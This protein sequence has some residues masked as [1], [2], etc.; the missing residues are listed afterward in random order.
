MP[1]IC[2]KCSGLTTRCQYQTG[3]QA[4]FSVSQR[5]MTEVQRKVEAFGNKFHLQLHSYHCKFYQHELFL[6]IIT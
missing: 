1:A 4:H 2:S 6:H 3:H 5:K